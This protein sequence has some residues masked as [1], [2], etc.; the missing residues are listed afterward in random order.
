MITFQTEMKIMFKSIVFGYIF[1]PDNGA[2]RMC[3][4]SFRD[5]RQVPRI[6]TGFI[7]AKQSRWC[8]KTGDDLMKKLILSRTLLTAALFVS[9][10]TLLVGQEA[11]DQ[12]FTDSRDGNVYNTVKI[13]DQ[14]WMAQNLNFATETGSW[15]LD[16]DPD[17]TQFGRFYNWEAAKK[18]VPPGWHLPS[19]EEFEIMLTAVGAEK[20]PY[21]GEVFNKLVKGGD[22]GFD[23][24]MT[25]SYKEEYSRRGSS[26]AFWS[27]DLWWF[28]SFLPRI[29]RPMRL[30]LRTPDYINIGSGAESHYG[31]NVRCIKDE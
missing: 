3:N 7:T 9:I 24:S 23:V 26:A 15:C 11:P 18:A 2:F 21:W 31:F 4:I 19:K 16:D 14:E 25:G 5:C 1:D 12:S 13:G 10:G 30:S 22:S 8:I 20:L 29:E 28:S 17:G 27:S 6:P